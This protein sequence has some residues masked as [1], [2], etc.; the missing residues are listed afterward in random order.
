VRSPFSPQTSNF[1]S[2]GRRADGAFFSL[3]FFY[4]KKKDKKKNKKKRITG[5]KKVRELSK[6]LV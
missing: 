2:R 3:S 6:N 5:S 1:F 4:S